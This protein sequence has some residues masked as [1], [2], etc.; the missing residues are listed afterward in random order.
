MSG[1]ATVWY[2]NGNKLSE[3]NYLDDEK[4]GLETLWNEKGNKESETIY[5]DGNKN[6]QKTN[7]LTQEIISRCKTQMAEY[8]AAMVKACVDQDIAAFKTLGLYMENHKAIITRCLSQ[9]G[10]YGYVMVKACA[11]QDIEAENALRNY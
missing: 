7:N 8:G 3:T 10:E 6:T 9:M 5:K 4:N 2:W 11:D 1:L